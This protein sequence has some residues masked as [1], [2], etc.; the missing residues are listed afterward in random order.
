M[1]QKIYGKFA[2]E[3]IFSITIFLCWF[4]IFRLYFKNYSFMS[5][6]LICMCVCV[7]V[8]LC[9]SVYS[10]NIYFKIYTRI[11]QS[12][13][14]EEEK[15]DKFLLSVLSEFDL[16]YV[17]RKMLKMYYFVILLYKVRSKVLYVCMLRSR[18]T[19][20]RLSSPN[21]ESSK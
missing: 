19:P 2:F 17:A 8:C 10:R 5:I 18:K 12:F 15:N 6:V 14:K 20:I 21:Q 1:S 11:V 16:K 13:L 4:N 3:Y 7:C 9:V